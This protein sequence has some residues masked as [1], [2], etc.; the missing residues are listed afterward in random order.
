MLYVGHSLQLSHERVVNADG[1]RHSRLVGRQALYLYMAAE[2]Y[3]LV[4]YGVFEAHDDA[5]RHNH[6]RQSDGHA[7][8]CNSNGRPAHLFLVVAG[9]IDAMCKE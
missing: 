2:A 5:D 7:E 4:A 1:C 8:C 6:Y 9:L 3:H